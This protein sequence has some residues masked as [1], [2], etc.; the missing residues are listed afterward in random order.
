MF[1]ILRHQQNYLNCSG[2]PSHL[3][4]W[5]TPR[6]Q[7]TQ[8]AGEDVGKR[9]PCSLLVQVQTGPTTMEIN[10]EA[11][12]RTKN[13]AGAVA[14]RWSACLAI[15]WVP[16]PASPN[17][18]TVAYNVFVNGREFS[19]LTEE[20]AGEAEC[21]RNP[22]VPFQTQAY[23]VRCASR[24]LISEV[25]LAPLTLIQGGKIIM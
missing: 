24:P 3:S 22:R 7:R 9:N 18:P 12:P 21:Y 14:Q 19:G 23:V 5:W 25:A 20:P 17:I 10:T 6:R 11:F 4:E 2:I 15:A 1:S 13:R 8:K 16:F